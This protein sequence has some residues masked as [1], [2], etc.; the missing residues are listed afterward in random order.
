MSVASQ[1]PRLSGAGP[2][3]ETD[4]DLPGLGAALWRQ[5]WKILVP[6]ILAGLIALAA[7]QLITPK[8][9][10]E[11]RVLIESRDNVFLRPDVDKDV[12][13][14]GTVDPETVTSQ[15]QLI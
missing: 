1:S 13:D 9:Q 7:V 10:S 15:V 6:T 4:L 12:L 11:A 3:A 8:Y 2:S 5:K 14:R